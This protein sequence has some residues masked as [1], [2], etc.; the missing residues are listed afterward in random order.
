NLPKTIPQVMGNPGQIH[1]VLMNLCVNAR[2]AIRDGGV[3]TLALDS[4]KLERHVTGAD[5]KIV[6]GD[7]VV[8]S[9]SDTGHGISSEI[10]K[11][12][13]DLCCPKKPEG[14]GT[15]WGFPPVKSIVQNHEGF[16]EVISQMEKGA[17]FKVFL[18]V[19]RGTDVASAPPVEAPPS[20][21]GETI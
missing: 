8:L 6:S 19:A 5:S 2:D 20:G 12:I 18:P 14:V 10:I 21:N 13:F 4:V 17:T 7:F 16:I 9:V 1:Q 15:G 3:L 11:K